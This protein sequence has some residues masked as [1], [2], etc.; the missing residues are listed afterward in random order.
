MHIAEIVPAI[1]SHNLADAQNKIKLVEPFVRR[2]QIDVMDGQFVDNKTLATDEYASI[3][4]NLIR[5]VQLMVR[6]P[7]A[8]LNDCKN[9]GIDL[10]EFHLESLGNPWSV[11]QKA[12]S[13]GL[14]IGIALNPDTPLERARE[15]LQSID[16]ILLMSVNPGFGG[17]EFLP[18]TIERIK[19][20]RAMWSKGIIEVDGGL[21]KGIVGQC[22]K[23]GANFL[24]VGSGIFGEENPAQTLKDL[25]KEVQKLDES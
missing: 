6:E 12:K 25:Q 14:K 13:L 15:Y 7:E 24:V 16:L 18:R 21:K 5:E 17:Q 22:A 1:L 19:L 23:A 2:V 20:L 3:K 10:M 8:Y 4:T 9:F 11:I